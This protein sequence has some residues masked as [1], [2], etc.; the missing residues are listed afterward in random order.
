[1]DTTDEHLTPRYVS[2]KQFAE[3]FGLS[4][5]TIA[6]LAKKG[7]IKSV[8]TAD[9]A[10]RLIPVSEIDRFEATVKPCNKPLRKGGKNA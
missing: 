2:P 9:V 5:K 7:A 4:A 10:R 1:M 8:H 3:V 6:S